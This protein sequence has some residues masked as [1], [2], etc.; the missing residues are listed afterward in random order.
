MKKLGI[1]KADIGSKMA[2]FSFS[3]K[4][5]LYERFKPQ[6]RMEVYFEKRDPLGETKKILENLAAPGA[7]ETGQKDMTRRR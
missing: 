4:S 7:R 5:G 6:G 3:P 2:A 1:E